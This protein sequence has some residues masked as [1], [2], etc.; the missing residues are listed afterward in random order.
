ML[1]C[2]IVDAYGPGMY[3]PSLLLQKGYKVIHIQSTKN[4]PALFRD[5]IE[6]AGFIRN[7][8]YDNNLDEIL[9]ILRNE[10]VVSIIPGF[11]TGVT[12]ADILTEHLGIKTNGTALSTARRN[13]SLMIEALQKK[14]IPTAASLKTNN[15]KAA[16]EWVETK[17]TYPV[18]AKPVD[19]AS[20]EDV[21]IC[22]NESELEIAC[23]KIVNKINIMGTKNNEVLI[24]NYLNGTEFVINSVSCDGKH[25]ISDIWECK[26][27]VVDNRIIYD[28]EELIPFQGKQQ[29]ELIPYI[30][31]VLDALNIKFGSAHSEVML[32]KNGPILLETGARVGGA[33]NPSI[34]NECLGHNQIE[35]CIDAY[36][37][38]T[39][40][41]MR[42]SMPYKI[43]KHLYVVMAISENEGVIEDITLEKDIKDKL[44]SF[45][46][47][48]L[49]KKRGERLQK[50]VD[51]NSSPATIFLASDN[52]NSLEAD[53][54]TLLKL[55]NTGFK[56]EK[57][58]DDI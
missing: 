5:F 26:K 37:N 56:L 50:T 54:Q 28:R 39:S 44:S 6:Q 1:T 13:K 7:I 32:T 9:S 38:P 34:H 58:S 33:V 22:Q 20:S 15:I 16:A 40:F 18:I 11:E 48:R 41:L 46:F 27:R 2:A 45:R 25:Y 21:Y 4:I 30:Y 49:K 53:Y 3:F 17:S 12:T 36:L 35:L 31:Q 52:K 55:I 24:Q 19:S 29:S 43:A 42:T 14:N 10:N 8:I 23:N 57:S 51:L 47:I